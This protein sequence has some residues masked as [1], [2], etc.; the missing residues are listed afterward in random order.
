M[1]HS[2][3]AMPPKARQTR[4]RRLP[5]PLS[6][7][8]ATPRSRH[9]LRRS[10][11]KVH[12]AARNPLRQSPAPLS[13]V[14]RH[15]SHPTLRRSQVQGPLRLPPSQVRQHQSQA[16]L[17]PSQHLSPAKVHRSQARTQVKAMPRSRASARPQAT[18]CRDRCL[19]PA[20]PAAWPITHFPRVGETT[21]Q[22]HAPVALRASAATA[23]AIT[24]VESAAAAMKVAITVRARIR[25]KARV[26]ADVVHR[27]P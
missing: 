3:V 23:P 8:R 22:A 7:A 15:R 16:P 20:D 4:L 12:R 6:P 25:T 17:L 26:A 21:A 9:R 18:P 5:S 24:A 13:Q 11:V 14:H 1:K 2:P 10:Q 19:S 27:L